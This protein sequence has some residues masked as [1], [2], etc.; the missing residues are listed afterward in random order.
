MRYPYEFKED[1]FGD[2]A[3]ILPKEISIFSAFI[4]DI[5]SIEEVDEYTGYIQNVIGGV[6]EKFEI[7]L[8][9]QPV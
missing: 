3:I 4:Q 5:S 7:T 8:K 9:M 2:L 6:Y 1:Q